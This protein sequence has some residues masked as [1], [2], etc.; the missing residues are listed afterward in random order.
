MPVRFLPVVILPW[1]IAGGAFGLILDLQFLFR[2]SVFI[3]V[4]SI[5]LVLF[6]LWF[7]FSS[8]RDESSSE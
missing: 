7:E 2:I 8:R 4:V 3:A 6:V 1:S 5:P